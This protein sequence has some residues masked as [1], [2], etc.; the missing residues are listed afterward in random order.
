MATTNL[1]DLKM[2][3]KELSE[4]LD[5]Q[6]ALA[7]YQL[8]ENKLAQFRFGLRPL[9]FGQ[10]IQLILGAVIAGVAPQFWIN[11]FGAPHLLISGLFLQAYGIMFI[12]FALRDLVLIRRI[13]YGAPVVAIQKQLAEL[14]VW[15]IRTA[16]WHGL[17]G[18]V[19]WLPVMLVLLYMLGTDLVINTPQKMWWLVSSVVVC[20][21]LNC[22]LVLL[23]RSRR[24]WGRALAASWVGCSV[25]RAQASLNEIEEFEREL[26]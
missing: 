11:H 25:R 22:G 8:K 16:I 6:N 21:A 14:R 20:L 4:K 26:A 12:A 5:K 15:H 7:L 9:V 13:D 23:A 10:I 17:T 3:W 1:D 18:S 2:A 24:K 19:M